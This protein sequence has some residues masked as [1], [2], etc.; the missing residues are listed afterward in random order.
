MWMTRLTRV[1]IVTSL[2]ER[3]AEVTAA[4]SVDSALAALEHLKADVL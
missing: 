1:N 2:E 4:G 3:G